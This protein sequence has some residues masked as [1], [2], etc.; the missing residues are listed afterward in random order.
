MTRAY[1]AFTE[2]GLALAKKLAEA[3]PGSVT[4]CGHGGVSLADWTAQEFPRQDALIFVGAVGIAVRAIAPHC[5]SKAT[6]PAVVVVDECGRFAVPLLSGHL[7]GANDLARDISTVCGAV[8]VITTATDANGIF[9][10]DEWAK[11]QNCMVLE[12]ERIKQVSGKLLAGNCTA[13]WSDF[14]IEEAAPSGVIPAQTPDTSDFFL[15]LF[16]SGD[17]L[18]LVPRIG[19]LG[20]GCKRG[21]SAQQL[22]SAF[23]FFCEMHRLAPQCIVSSASIDLKQNE[24]GLLTFCKNHRWNIQFFSA[25]QLQAAPGPFTASSFV[26]SITGVDNVCERAAVLAS[27]GSIRIPKQAGGGVTFALALRPFAPNWRWQHG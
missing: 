20:V 2:K 6:D 3:L 17:A 7:G 27:G 11:H 19:V 1:L 18:H 12:P 22:E 4:R 26:Q 9:A 14:S 23:T 25:E 8:P 16:P 15:T 10:V 21:T 13:Y 5:H 24:E